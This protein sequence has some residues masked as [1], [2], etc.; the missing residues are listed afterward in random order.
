MAATVA[1]VQGHSDQ[2]FKMKSG[3]TSLYHTNKRLV[4]ANSSDLRPLSG[5]IGSDI[6][7]AV[8]NRDSQPEESLR[9]VMY[10]NCWGQG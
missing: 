5:M 1:V 2:G 4:S 10:L 9:K 6:S 3:V 7:G 8:G